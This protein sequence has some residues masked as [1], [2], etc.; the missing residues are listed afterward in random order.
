MI[1]GSYHF[2]ANK[3]GGVALPTMRGTI[4]DQANLVISKVQR[5]G[6][7]DLAPALD[8]EDEPRLA[9]GRKVPDGSPPGTGRYTIDEGLTPAQP[10]YHSRSIRSNPNRQ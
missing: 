2:F 5:L 1:R 4:A 9:N 10:G 8:L 7:G 6:P 3:W